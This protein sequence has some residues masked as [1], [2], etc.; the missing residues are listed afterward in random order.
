VLPT[1]PSVLTQYVSLQRHFVVHGVVLVAANGITRSKFCP[2]HVFRYF[3]V[4]TGCEYVPQDAANSFID[5]IF[6]S[7]TTLDGF[8][9]IVLVPT[10]NMQAHLVETKKIHPPH[11]GGV[12]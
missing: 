12:Q 1:G 11:L 8:W 9:Y 2:G 10:R 4:D 6:I 5:R 3:V 7:Q